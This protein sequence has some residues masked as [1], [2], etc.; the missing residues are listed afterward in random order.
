MTAIADILDQIPTR[1][2]ER[3]KFTNLPAR[4]KKLVLEQGTLGWSDNVDIL[5]K[6]A[7][8]ADKYA[9]TALWDLNLQNTKDYRFIDGDATIDVHAQAEKWYS[10]YIRIHIKKGQ[11]ATVIE[12][13]SGDSNY[14]K[15]Q[16]V[17]IVLEDGAILNHIR[18]QD[19]A[20][21]G[22]FTNFTHVTCAKDARYNACT[23]TR[24][25]GLSRNQIHA[26]LQGS[27]ADATINGVKLLSGKQHA[28][29][30]ITIEH[31]APDCTSNQ[32]IRSVLAGES[33]GVFQG[34]VHVH[35]IAQKTD[36]Y[37]LSNALLL[38]DLAE[39]DTKP[40]LEI[41]ADDVKC[42]H[43]AT[44]GQLDEEPLF[45]M[46]ARGIP[47]AAARMLLIQA[48]LA[49]IVDKIGD[50]SVKPEAEQAIEEW[51]HAHAGA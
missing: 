31:Q 20:A 14:W 40:E 28:D 7:P 39:M 22:V 42:S 37:Q 38:S 4:L 8:G 17:D 50:E 30:T 29:T 9:D 45:Y 16:V 35:Q 13:Q 24:G 12:K 1:K 18:F 36:G 25:E 51:L 33:R 21:D 2:S 11:Q 43:G 49:E 44:T 46:Q 47:R 5:N 15:N 10:P 23:L 27:G 6:T 32:F 48:F 26:E 3:F 19:E 34:K 41:Y